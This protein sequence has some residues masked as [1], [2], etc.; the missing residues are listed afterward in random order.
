[1]IPELETGG[2]ERTTI[3]IAQALVEA[4]HD[5]L[6]VSQGGRMVAELPAQ[7]H[8]VTMPAASKNPATMWANARRL[9]RLC[10]D[11]QVDVLHARSRAPAWSAYLAA[12]KL[13]L[14]FVTTYHGAY[15]AQNG[16]K[17]QYNS[18]MARADAVIANSRF[19]AA[20]II[21]QFPY[22]QD[23]IT[24][25]PRGTDLSRSDGTAEPYAW[26][27]PDG[28]KLVLHIARLTEWKGQ[29]V[30]IGALAQL[31]D[32][33]HLVLAGEDQ[34]RTRYTEGLKAQAAELGLSAR[35]HFVG[36]ADPARAL[37]SAD[38]CVVP[39]IRPEA[40]GRAAVE[41]QAAGVPVIVSKLGAVPETVLAPPEVA[42]EDRTGWHVA[43]GDKEALADAIIGALNLA[44]GARDAHIKRAQAHV[45]RRFSLEAM[46]EATL[47]VYDSLTA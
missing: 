47:A 19:T 7:A 13:K 16:L 10:R 23:A 1:M 12:R 29:E 24:V 40:F 33:V 36:H 11:E 9:A 8:H 21:E 30:A 42:D 34:G 37:A 27:I 44:P 17:Q 39:S 2:A 38:V 20:S 18:V 32:D 28:A 46:C 4:G 43:A 35:V 26:P 45:H 15:K 6:V 5:A 14:P 25:I 41:A 3:D 31:P 22:A